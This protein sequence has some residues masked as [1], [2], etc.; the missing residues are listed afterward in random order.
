VA[1]A[2]AILPIEDILAGEVFPADQELKIIKILNEITHNYFMFHQLFLF[3]ATLAFAAIVSAQSSAFPRGIQRLL[4]LP[5]D[6]I[7]LGIAAL[8]F[9]KKVYPDIDV[10]AYSQKV[11][12]LA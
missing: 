9:A 8:T 3:I 1:T 5:D 6:D 11:D 12:G 2:I 10:S 7:D 4:A